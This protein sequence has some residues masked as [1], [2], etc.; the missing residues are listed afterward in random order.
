M[1]VELP[2][3]QVVEVAGSS[4][5]TFR[6]EAHEAI[7]TDSGCAARFAKAQGRARR[8][9]GQLFLSGRGMDDVRADSKL[10]MDACQRCPLGALHA[11]A[12]PV[13]H[14]AHY[15]SDQCPRCGFGTNRMIAGRVC[16]NCYNREREVLSGRNG[17]GNRPKRLAPIHTFSMRLAVDGRRFAAIEDRATSA[18][19]V[20]CRQ[21]RTIKG[22]VAFAPRRRDLVPQQR[23][24]A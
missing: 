5:R 8:T 14:S 20:I 2:A 21:L 12:A 10:A 23:L 24:F 1:Q 15:A 18:T 7:V 13:T 9:N 22:A 17:R 4:L 3:Y 11:G 6:C 16:V 19:E